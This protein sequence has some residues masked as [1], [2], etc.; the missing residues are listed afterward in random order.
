MYKQKIA[1]LLAMA[2]DE[3]S[4]EE[5]QVALLKARELMAKHKLRQDEC[6]LQD[7]KV[8]RELVGVSVTSVKY[9]WAVQLSAIIA[10]HYCCASFMQR[11]S[12]GR[13]RSIGFIGLE[14]DFEVCRRIF[15]YAFDCVKTEADRWFKSDAKRRSAEVRRKNAE[16]YGWG[17]LEG[18]KEQ[19]ARQDEEHQE[20]GLVLKLPNEVRREINSM[21][22]AKPFG[23]ITLDDI[24]ACIGYDAGLGFEPSTK[25]EQASAPLAR[26]M[27]T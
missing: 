23:K 10:E 17:F 9:G 16:A 21:E 25:L 14:D 18:L 2:Q 27:I 4:P 8:V 5:A 26:R 15:L 7:A 24:V 12:R 20:W 13:L 11:R 6:V 3:S 1:K 19:Y 22:K